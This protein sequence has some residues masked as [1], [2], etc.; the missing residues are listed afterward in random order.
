MLP[1]GHN[2]LQLIETKQVPEKKPELR[3]ELIRDFESPLKT[4][5]KGTI[6]TERGW[7]ESFIHLDRG[8]CS[9]KKDWF[10]AVDSKAVDFDK[11]LFDNNLC[12]GCLELD[13]LSLFRKIKAKVG[14]EILNV[15][16][17]YI[18]NNRFSTKDELIKYYSGKTITDLDGKEITFPNFI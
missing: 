1:A 18:K 13:R 3:Y 11:F 17:E 12:L 14:N 8:D 10:K 16:M 4:I 9:I 15:G 7:I 6:Q 5:K 2:F